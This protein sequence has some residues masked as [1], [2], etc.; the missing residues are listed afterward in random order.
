MLVKSFGFKKSGIP[1]DSN[2]VFDVRSIR[3]PHDVEE[4]RIQNGKDRDVINYVNSDPNTTP[5][6]MSILDTIRNTHN[7]NLVISIGCTGGKHRS[8]VIASRL[9]NELECEVK[10]I[11]L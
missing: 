6:I 11:E 3:N 4:L 10:H 8:V 7:E 1:A 5:L 9:A 2:L